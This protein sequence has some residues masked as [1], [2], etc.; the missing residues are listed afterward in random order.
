MPAFH[1]NARLLINERKRL[2]AEAYSSTNKSRFLCSYQAIKSK[3]YKAAHKRFLFVRLP[4]LLPSVSQIAFW[5]AAVLGMVSLYFNIQHQ[6]GV[7]SSSATSRSAELGGGI[8]GRQQPQQ[9]HQ[10]NVGLINGGI[11][12]TGTPP[13]GVV[14]MISKGSKRGSRSSRR[15]RGSSNGGGYARV[16]GEADWDEHG[17][18]G[19]MDSEEEVDLGL[20]R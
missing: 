9:Q 12:K 20:V 17:A 13:V 15:K 3:S 4:S 7:S 16:N 5:V 8:Y 18:G 19:M 2:R 14:E 1:T 11:V 6:K 10:H